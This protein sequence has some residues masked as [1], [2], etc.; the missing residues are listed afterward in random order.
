MTYRYKEPWYAG[1]AGII[2]V[3]IVLIVLGFAWAFLVG[4]LASQS[5]AESTLRTQGFDHIHL[6]G[7][8]NVAVELFGCGKEDVAKF[9]FTAQNVRGRTVNVSVC[10]GWPFKGATIRGT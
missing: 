5:N 8:D 4:S 3:G 2:A 7:R 6:V 9:N 10:E 1:A